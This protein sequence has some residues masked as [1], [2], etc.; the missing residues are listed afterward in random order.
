MTFRSTEHSWAFIAEVDYDP[1]A[2]TLSHY[3][4]N[5]VVL[6][7]SKSEFRCLEWTGNLLPELGNWTVFQDAADAAQFLEQN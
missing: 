1:S 5:S 3:E 7:A 2:I 4:V 6:S